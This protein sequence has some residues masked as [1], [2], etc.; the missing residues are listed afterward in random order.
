MGPVLVYKFTSERFHASQHRI[1]RL[2]ELNSGLTER[3]EIVEQDFCKILVLL[4]RGFTGFRQILLGRNGQRIDIE[5][6]IESNLVAQAET[7][8]RS[9]ARDHFTLALASAIDV[10]SKRIEEQIRQA[11]LSKS[12]QWEDEV[13]GLNALREAINRW[14]L[15]LDFAGFLSVNGSLIP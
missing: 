15:E 8:A 12:D 1:E 11:R 6:G 2:L 5:L 4:A 14:D 7:V 13:A 10:E 9:A 3:S